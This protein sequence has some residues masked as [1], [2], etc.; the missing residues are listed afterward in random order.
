MVLFLSSCIEEPENPQIPE[1][2]TSQITQ[3]RDW[4]ETNKT[5]LRL[6]ERGSNFRTESQELILPFFEK[7]P[8]WDQFH[9]YYFPD[10]R[11]VFE[12]S[13]LNAQSYIP[14]EKGMDASGEV[15]SL[16]IQNI[17]FVRHPTEQRFDP[18]IIRYY[19]DGAISERDFEEINYQGIDEKWNGWIDL[20]TY[21][22]HYLMGYRISEGQLTHTRTMKVS[23]ENSRKIAIGSENKDEAYQ[24][25]E[26]ATDWY[27]GISGDYLDTT[28]ATT[29][30]WTRGGSRGGAGGGYLGD[31]SGSGAGGTDGVGGNGNRDE[32]DYEPPTVPRPIQ[33]LNCMDL[34]NTHNGVDIDLWDFREKYYLIDYDDIIR[35]MG[36][37][38]ITNWG[39]QAG[40]PA[41]DYRYVR[42]PLNPRLIIDMRHLLVVGRH[43]PAFG[44]SVEFAQWLAKNESGFDDQDFYSNELGYSFFEH[45]GEAINNTPEYTADWLITFLNDPKLRNETSNPNRCNADL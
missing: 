38:S 20:F 12:T 16:V 26:V 2:E 1:M 15:G 34:R 3:V 5:R 8:D 31:S 23:S 13:L 28:H 17:L 25:Y 40:G 14:V 21:D 33:K 19:P 39:S 32:D 10:G 9:H 27:D 7:E 6:P 43:G 24:C 42:D 36:D 45:Y 29:C 11:E 30:E 37:V 22:E 44:N 4:F 18:L 41:A 35:E